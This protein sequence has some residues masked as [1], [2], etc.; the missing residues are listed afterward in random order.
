MIPA[1]SGKIR[2]MGDDPVLLHELWRTRK[3]GIAPG[4]KQLISLLREQ[5]NYVSVLA[6][7]STGFQTSISQRAKGVQ[8]ENMNTERGTVVRVCR[9]GQYAEAAFTGFDPSFPE[10]AYKWIRTELEAQIALL[11][12]TG[13]A[14]YA[15]PLLP[16]E[17][18]TIFEEMETERLP[19]EENLEALIGILSGISDRGMAE[20]KDLVDCMARASSTHVSKLFL[21][22]NR[23]YD[24]QGKPFTTSSVDDRKTVTSTVNTM[25]PYYALAY[26][27]R[28]GDCVRQR[29]ESWGY[30]NQIGTGVEELYTPVAVRIVSKSGNVPSAEIFMEHGR[31]M[32]A[33]QN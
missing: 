23:I 10:K 33:R 30:A 7:D 14:P 2:T 22:E 32:A 5:Y 21:T 28:N 16:D 24:K 3:S 20:G 13:T 8:R 29:S 15:T 9:D 18:R 4:L 6:T 25:P 12:E 17:E 11:R 19:E 1:A 27:D 26:I 31:I